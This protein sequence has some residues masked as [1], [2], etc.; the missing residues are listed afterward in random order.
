MA[1]A[2]GTDPPSLGIFWRS[3]DRPPTPPSLIFRPGWAHCKALREGGCRRPSGRTR[4]TV[5]G[6]GMDPENHRS[7]PH[8][9]PLP[10]RLRQ[11]PDVRPDRRSIIFWGLQ[12]CATPLGDVRSAALECGGRERRRAMEPLGRAA[13]WQ[14]GE[15]FCAVLYVNPPP[16]SILFG[17][18][19]RSRTGGNL[20]ILFGFTLFG[21]SVI[22]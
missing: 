10:E 9:I 20:F 6:P 22:T 13:R 3:A 19:S 8:S 18:R 11:S 16:N 2:A 1:L 12:R 14:R 17:H 5:P 21:Q 4:P 7:F 15:D